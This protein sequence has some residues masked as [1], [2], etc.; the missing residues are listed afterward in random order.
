MSPEILSNK[1]F[2]DF[3][4]LGNEARFC[5]HMFTFFL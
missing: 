3:S 4:F 2:R 5:L 1:G